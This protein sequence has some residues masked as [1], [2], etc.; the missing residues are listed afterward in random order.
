MPLPRN[1]IESRWLPDPSGFVGP[2]LGGWVYFFYLASPRN[3]VTGGL[4]PQVVG[5]E[6][7]TGVV[8]LVEEV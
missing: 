6:E 8:L 3:N 1:I 7:F 4:S 5:V 2:V